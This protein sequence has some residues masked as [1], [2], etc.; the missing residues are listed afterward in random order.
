MGF[1]SIFPGGANVTGN[2][3]ITFVLAV[4]T[5]VIVQIFGTKSI[6]KKYFGRTFRCGLKFRFLSC[7]LLSWWGY[8]QSR[9][10]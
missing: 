4:C 6:G 2:I 7:R 8:L 3:A 10:R 9:L 1:N 5:F